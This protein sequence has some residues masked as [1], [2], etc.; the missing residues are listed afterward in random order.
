MVK[1]FMIPKN[2]GK[3]FVNIW[4]EH[5]ADEMLKW[6]QRNMR[7]NYLYD[8]W[9]E[10]NYHITVNWISGRF[11]MLAKQMEKQYRKSEMEAPRNR[12]LVRCTLHIEWF[13]FGWCAMWIVYRVHCTQWTR[14][15]RTYSSSIH[16]KELHIWT[17]ESICCEII[18]FKSRNQYC[19]GNEQVSY[20]FV[21]L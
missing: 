15:N 12:K 14:T 6:M 17:M 3:L 8:N 10:L 13:L 5:V 1:W 7:Y 18:H 2:I 16:N 11:D 4:H 20:C 9:L 21:L 19:M